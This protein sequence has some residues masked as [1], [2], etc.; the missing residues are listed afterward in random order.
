MERDNS[1][2]GSIVKRL[3]NDPGISKKLV[4]KVQA[5]KAEFVKSHKELTDRYMINGKT[6]SDWNNHFKLNIPKDATPT[7]CKEIMR[8][9][10]E[11]HH[12]A[13]FYYSQ[14]SMTEKAVLGR[15]EAEHREAYA[16]GLT[17]SSKAL[18]PTPAT[19]LKITADKA[20]QEIDDILVNA[21]ITQAFWKERI[22]HLKYLYK[23]VNDI[24]INTGYEI[25]LQP[26]AS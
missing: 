21:Q 2:I 25:K 15:R 11:L 18:K 24:T 9:L 20:V 4:E 7:Q 14:A 3:K 10:A 19:T 23:L 26:G 6:I 1:G 12:E 8:D 13:T 16:N 5:G 22:E 17:E